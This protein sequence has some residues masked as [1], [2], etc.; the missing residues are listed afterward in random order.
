MNLRAW[1]S[2]DFRASWA[3]IEVL[4][5]VIATLAN[6]RSGLISGWALTSAIAVSK[7]ACCARSTL[8]WLISVGYPLSCENTSPARR[9]ISAAPEVL[10]EAILLIRESIGEAF[11]GAI[12]VS[13]W[14]TKVA[15]SLPDFS[16]FD[17]IAA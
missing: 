5:A 10:F 14:S 12:D 13:H 8:T 2:A 17:I 1:S 11:R 6:L 15:D 7:M 16:T 3:L 4:A 9:R